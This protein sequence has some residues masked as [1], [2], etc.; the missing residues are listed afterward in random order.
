MSLFHF[1]FVILNSKLYGII[2][3][4]KRKKEGFLNAG[5]GAYNDVSVVFDILFHE[6]PTFVSFG[7]GNLHH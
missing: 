4:R 2:I 6:I 3:S 1:E 7:F 5:N